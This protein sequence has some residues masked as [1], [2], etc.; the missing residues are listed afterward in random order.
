MSGVEELYLSAVEL[1]GLS[2]LPGELSS[3]IV[4]LGAKAATESTPL[5]HVEKHKEIKLAAQFLHSLVTYANHCKDSNLM[6]HQEIY[7]AVSRWLAEQDRPG[8]PCALMRN[9]TGSSTKEVWVP[10][11]P[12]SHLWTPSADLTRALAKDCYPELTTPLALNRAWDVF[13][14]ELMCLSCLQ[15]FETQDGRIIK[16]EGPS[17]KEIEVPV[18]FRRHYHFTV[19][20]TWPCTAPEICFHQFCTV[21]HGIRSAF[22]R[23][24]ISSDPWSLYFEQILEPKAHEALMLWF[25]AACHSYEDRPKYFHDHLLFVLVIDDCSERCGPLVEGWKCL[26]SLLSH[27]THGHFGF[28]SS[29]I[30]QDSSPPKAKQVHW[31]WASET[32]PSSFTWE[33]RSHL[34]LSP[35]PC[36]HLTPP[37][38]ED[39]SPWIR[40]AVA[41]VAALTR[42][43]F[44]D[45]ESKSLRLPG[46]LPDPS[47]GKL[48]YWSAWEEIVLASYKWRPVMPLPDRLDTT[49]QRVI[50]T[51]MQSCLTARDVHDLVESWANTMDVAIDRR[52]QKVSPKAALATFE[53]YFGP[54]PGLRILPQT[55]DGQWALAGV[56]SSL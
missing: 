52:S 25:A 51:T 3:F 22:P 37:P 14:E 49:T 30:S 28:L 35:K 44:Q 47:T 21:K 34:L 4:G 38:L 18:S 56:A 54:S 53:K 26:L 32:P 42:H 27:E 2:D 24:E 43:P 45:P 41:S 20:Q 48:S 31:A 55:F 7:L 36:G 19:M 39:V 50:R 11:K 8:E 23:D 40:R 13:A 5:L 12:G 16:V 6:P 29:L 1:L 9:S 17:I 33:T 15:A 46:L 10:T